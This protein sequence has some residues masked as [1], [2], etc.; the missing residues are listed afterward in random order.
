MTPNLHISMALQVLRERGKLSP[1]ELSV[2]AGLPP[3]AVSRIESGEMSLDYLTATRLTQVLRINLAEI[4]VTAHG[5][6]HGMVAEH[7]R[8]AATGRRH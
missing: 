7:F 4:A 3:G 6:D 2:S 8:N 5:L 1:D